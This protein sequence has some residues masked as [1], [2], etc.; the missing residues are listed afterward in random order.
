MA[1]FNDENV[2]RWRR[3][4]I[5]LVEPRCARRRIVEANQGVSRQPRLDVRRAVRRRVVEDDVQLTVAVLTLNLLHKGEE[6]IAGVTVTERMR[7]PAG[8]N[9]ESSENP[10]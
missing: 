3:R 4:G 6:V 9:L 8:R 7:D 2:G 1:G 10:S 5:Y